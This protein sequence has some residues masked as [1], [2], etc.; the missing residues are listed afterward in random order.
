MLTPFFSGE[1]WTSQTFHPRL[2]S[3]PILNLVLPGLFSF[4]LEVENALN[5]FFRPVKVPLASTPSSN[6]W[7]PFFD[8]RFPEL[9]ICFFILCA[10]FLVPGNQYSCPDMSPPPHWKIGSTHFPLFPSYCQNPIFPPPPCPPLFPTRSQTR[11]V[12]T[13]ECQAPNRLTFQICNAIFCPL[14]GSIFSLTFPL[15]LFFFANS[16]VQVTSCPDPPPRSTP[17]VLF[18]VSSFWL[19]NLFSVPLLFFPPPPSPFN[20]GSVC[21]EFP[22]DLAYFRNRFLLIFR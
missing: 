4:S 6:P 20:T 15:F 3:L 17:L 10:A 14:L 9:F 12:V 16:V 19:F 2:P 21:Q 1:L 5:T 13:R 7:S 11:M 18:L 8:T 22:C